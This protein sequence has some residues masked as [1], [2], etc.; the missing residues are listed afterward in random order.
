[1]TLQR[2]KAKAG[3]P[4]FT[5]MNAERVSRVWAEHLQSGEPVDLEYR[6]KRAADGTYRWFLARGRAVR[7][8]DGRV[9]KWFGMLTDIDDQKQ[10]AKGRHQG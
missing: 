8:R 6:L 2:R 7:D 3:P 1:M 9:V 4:S 5:P 10:D